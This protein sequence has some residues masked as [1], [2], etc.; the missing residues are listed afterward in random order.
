MLHDY[1]YLASQSPRR[2]ELLTQLGVRHE[3][4]LADADEDA[5]SLEAVLPGESPDDYVQRVCA[6]KAEAALRRRERRALPD[7][8]ILTSDTTVCLGG[9]ILGKPD[10]AAHAAAMLAKLFGS[11]H[12]VLTAVTVVSTL[13]MRHA[14]S[15]SNVVFRAMTP[16]EINRYVASGEPLG[17]AGAYG[18]QGRAAEFVERIEGSYSGIMGLPL[19][20]TAA[21]LRQANLRF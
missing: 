9:E 3:L 13:G 6:L 8:P 20:E 4:L 12:R 17:K 19:F 1:L 15:V 14:L 18:I 2:A 11:T 10:D 16:D 5:E 7:S 21:L